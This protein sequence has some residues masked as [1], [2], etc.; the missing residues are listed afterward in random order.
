VEKTLRVI[1]R[2]ETDGV[3]GRYAIGGAVAA[4]FYIEPFTTYDLDIFFAADIPGGL[5]TRERVMRRRARP[6][7]LRAGLCSFFRP[8]IRW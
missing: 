2:M 4:I 6:S 1:N 3:I 5:I 7:T 8:I